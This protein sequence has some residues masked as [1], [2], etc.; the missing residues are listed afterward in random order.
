MITAQLADGRTLEFPDG[1][2][3]AV[4]Q[5]T[6]KKMLGI[7]PAKYNMPPPE[8]TEEPSI[9]KWLT[10]EASMIARGAIPVLAG[11]TTGG[12]LG[13]LGGPATAALG[14]L[15]GG[16]AGGP[17]LKSLTDRLSP[18]PETTG[19]R[20]LEAAGGALGGAGT[21]LPALASLA[22]SAINPVMRGIAGTMARAPGAQ[23]AAAAPSAAAS[24]LVSEKTD[25]PVLG[26][27]ASISTSIGI[28]GM[29]SALSQRRVVGITADQLKARANDL[30][31]QAERAGVIVS[32]DKLKS[33]IASIK[34]AVD[35]AAYDP[36]LHPR[37]GAVLSRIGK[38]FES[39][40]LSLKKLELLRRV[41]NSAALSPEKDERRVA[42]VVIDKLDDM[43]EH[44]RPEDLE[45]GATDVAVPALQAARAT[46]RRVSKA[47]LI[48]RTY[49]KALNAAGANYTQAKLGTALRQ[50]F[51]SIADNDRLFRTFSKQEQGLILNIVRGTT[52]QNAARWLGK[53]A[54]HGVLSTVVGSGVGY[55][56]GGP[57]GAVGLPVAGLL[58][59]NVAA[60]IGK[61]RF[62]DLDELIRNG[63]IQ[64]TPS[65]MPQM[66]IRGLLSDPNYRGL[67]S[68]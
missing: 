37:V 56:L 68:Q 10:R 39:G 30:Y 51:R 7:A 18:A 55:G 67:L 61:N 5:R 50:K 44:L 65:L 25:N 60:Q 1:T 54:P 40:T 14:A 28:G 41:A 46:W 66:T 38:D 43:I 6:V 49:K 22:R 11:A 62:L 24:Q 2:D 58:S 9:K 34:E 57:A 48:D 31:T 29:A 42:H 59:E 17:L 53:F 13:M 4:I 32:G 19:E 35:D 20:M 23:L 16:L 21:Q 27:L 8:P 12:A 36:G 15:G 26:M 64:T 45:S 47:D 52:G 33:S 63:F 3:P